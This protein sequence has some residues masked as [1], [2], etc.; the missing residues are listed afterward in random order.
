MK[1][2]FRL[3]CELLDSTKIHPILPSTKHEDLFVDD[4]RFDVTIVNET[5]KVDSLLDICKRFRNRFVPFVKNKT[6]KTRMGYTVCSED[7]HQLF[8]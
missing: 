4:I 6:Q 8:T 2:S 3:D 1:C 7:F 5:Y